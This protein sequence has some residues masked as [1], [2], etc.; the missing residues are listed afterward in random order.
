MNGY[1]IVKICLPGAH[2]YRDGESLDHFVSR[3]AND[4]AADNTFIVANGDQL[5][6][7]W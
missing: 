2:F 4:M 3:I 1:G 6:H 7:G 5:Y